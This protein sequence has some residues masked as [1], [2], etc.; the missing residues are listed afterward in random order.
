MALAISTAF[1]FTIVPT[2]SAQETVVEDETSVQNTIIVTTRKREESLQDVPLAISAFSADEIEKR[3]LSQLED[4]ALQTPGLAF[5]DYSNGGYGT[6]VIRGT[7]QFVLTT[8][9]QN[10]SVFYDGVYIPRG[11]A[12][13]LGL[14]NVERIEVVKGP[15]SAL[16]GANSFAGAINYVS[17]DRSTSEYFGSLKGGVGSDGLKELTGSINIPLIE[18]MLA[19]SF[20]GTHSEF[21]GDFD[22]NNPNASLAPR[23]G[24]D[25]SIGGWE[26]DALS[27]GLTFESGAFSASLDYST[28][29]ALREDGPQFRFTRG[30]AATDFNCSPGGF[31]GANQAICGEI[32][33][34][35]I[36]GPSGVEGLLSDPRSYSEIET[37]ILRGEL[38]YE[39]SDTVSLS[40]LYGQIESD[41][42]A[43]GEASRDP[44]T[45]TSLFGQPFQNVFTVGP[46]GNFDYTTHEARANFDFE[47]GITATAGVFLL[48]G[49]D[50]DGFTFFFAPLGGVDQLTRPDVTFV[51]TN[52]ETKAI[53]GSIIVPLLDD[54]M[55]VG[56]E[57]R[58]AETEK[59]AGANQFESSPFTPRFTVDYE[60][61]DDNLLYG[62]IAKGVKSGGINSSA[63]VLED[64]EIFFDDDENITYEIGSKNVFLDG[65]ATLN[66][67]AFYIDW[68]NLQSSIS[69][70]N[71]GFTTGAITTNIGSAVSQGLEIDGSWNVTD[72][73]SLNAGL[74]V[75]DATYDDGTTSARTGSICDGVVCE[76]VT[77]VTSDAFG[78]AIIGGNE[79]PRSPDLQW[80]IG[81]QYDGQLANGWDYFIRGDVAGQG[82]QYVEEVN[83]AT[84]PERTLANLRGGISFKNVSAEVWVTN[85]F[86]EE[87]VSNAFFI[88]S[89]FQT[90]YVPTYGPA[91]RWGVSLKYDF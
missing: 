82:E 86:D 47:S 49:D 81:A 7:S 60:L 5:E 64:S 33:G 69:P 48:D 3:S 42:F 25:D 32:P 59:S 85:L 34:T 24:T 4:V 84:L 17:K 52:V 20:S 91:Q 56:L 31:T 72:S 39:L 43:V 62:T 50:F 89:A 13:D 9:E 80:N 63:V 6:P 67:A 44:V 35:P 19:V 90:D 76:T 22:N 66:V 16:Y 71:A 77:D 41:I 10:V 29:D 2:A 61:T 37:E 40:Y 57:A 74:A 14:T 11:Y 68:D 58:Y 26:K 8:L 36:P 21:D 30:S 55:H 28:Y 88:N 87:Y 70:I 79:L 73:F 1:T 51:E 75:I 15:Q 83:L 18:D 54:R 53:F 38:G 45:G 27:A 23:K 46:F 78:D 12:F 65:Q